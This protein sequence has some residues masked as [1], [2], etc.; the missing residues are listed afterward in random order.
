MS[1]NS[2]NEP[3]NLANLKRVIL[4][5]IELLKSSPIASDNSDS[6]GNF[7]DIL[8][9]LFKRSQLKADDYGLFKPGRKPISPIHESDEVEEE[10]AVPAGSRLGE[11]RGTS[12]SLLHRS[13]LHPAQVKASAGKSLKNFVPCESLFY[14]HHLGLNYKLSIFQKLSPKTLLRLRANSQIFLSL[15]PVTNKRQKMTFCGYRFVSPGLT[16]LFAFFYK[17][18]LITAKN[19][20]MF[21]DTYPSFFIEMVV[22]CCKLLCISI[23]NQRCTQSFLSV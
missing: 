23:F 20:F 21:L 10:N 19:C 9:C 8:C 6:E 13:R 18:V 4:A 11:N 16:P 12:A 3:V 5:V 7:N 1:S 2:V 14:L 22:K 15:V 17:Q